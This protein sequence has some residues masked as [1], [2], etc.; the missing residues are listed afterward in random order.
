MGK[1]EAT[2]EQQRVMH[3]RPGRQFYI[4][5]VT[6]FR[7]PCQEGGLIV[8]RHNQ[9]VAEMRHGLEK[10]ERRVSMPFR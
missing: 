6:G 8:G 2:A 4:Q 10:I 7:R 9:A 1:A 5:I 3:H